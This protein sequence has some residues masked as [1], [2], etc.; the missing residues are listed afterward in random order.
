MNSAEERRAYQR[1]YQAGRKWPLYIPPEPPA[2]VTR[3]LIIA[4]RSVRNELDSMQ[5]T[6]EQDD[7]FTRRLHAQI[8]VI[9]DALTKVGEWV[10][11]E[12]HKGAHE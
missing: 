6:L 10:V 11:G 2:T 12:V 1:G 5:A 8:D 4:L 9:D 7:D 3:E